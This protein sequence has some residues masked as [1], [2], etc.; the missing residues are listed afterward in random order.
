MCNTC[1]EGLCIR[2]IVPLMYSIV[3]VVTG[4]EFKLV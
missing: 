1:I 3:A 4:P 2:A